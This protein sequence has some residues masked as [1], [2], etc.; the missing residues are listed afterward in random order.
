M[1]QRLILTICFAL[2]SGLSAQTP[3]DIVNKCISALGGKEAIQK[4]Q[5]M[6]AEGILMIK[7]GSME[8]KGKFKTLYDGAKTWLHSNLKFGD[9][10]FLVTR[11]YDGKNAWQEMMGNVT[12]VPPLNSKN[13]AE[14][15][16]LLLIDAKSS[17][18]QGKTTE[19][20]GKKVSGI[21]VTN[22]NKTTT[23]FIDTETYLPREI[24]FKDQYFGQSKQKETLEKRVRLMDYKKQ[25]GMLFPMKRVFY[26]KGK[27]GIE[28]Q[29]N[30][31]SF[32]ASIDG[33]I[34]IRPDKKKDFSYY[35]EM[36]H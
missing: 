2:V 3:K 22:N 17:F 29:F 35:E 26:E 19:I 33:S 15:S 31:I 6:S 25:Q 12:D 4:Q 34:F 24:L 10:E 7:Y 8:L 20:E 1:K 18:K 9:R 21:E 27:R 14:H 28:L 32:P 30:K 36:I 23:F 16:I 5:T 13:D 11:A